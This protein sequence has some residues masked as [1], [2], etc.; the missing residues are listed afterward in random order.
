MRI[1]RLSPEEQAL[2]A[3]VARTARP[4][5]GKRLKAEAQLGDGDSPP[6]PVLPRPE[7]RAAPAP[8]P[9]AIRPASGP[10]D[11]LDGSWDKRIAKGDL[12]PDVTIDLHGETLATAHVRLNRGLESA[13]R[14]GDRTLLL[15]TGK[16]AVDNPRLPPT[17]RGVIRASVTDW[18]AASAYADRI[19]AIRNAHPRH[20]GAGAL[21]IILRRAR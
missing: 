5:P 19:A 11:T 10:R 7:R 2:W 4:M 13:I 21:Y 18:L 12:A 16:P 8:R 3:R 9:A 15:I 17:S 6:Q 20:G 1:R 14:R